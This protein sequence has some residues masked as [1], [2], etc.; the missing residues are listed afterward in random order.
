MAKKRDQVDKGSGNVFADLG[1]PDAKER[2]VKVQLAAEVNRVLKERKLTQSKAA[3]VLGI[4]QPH[5]SDL[6]RYR[7]DRFSSERL[8]E[9]LTRLGKSV[10]IRISSRSPR[11]REGVRVSHLV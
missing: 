8:M 5:V 9:F 2:T 4:V 3:D 11:S 10:E 1:Y 7:L 6:A